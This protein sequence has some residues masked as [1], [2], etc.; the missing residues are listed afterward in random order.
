MEVKD[1]KAWALAATSGAGWMVF[2]I[3][4]SRVG[5]KKMQSI[6]H[7][8]NLCNKATISVLKDQNFVWVVLAVRICSAIIT[9]VCHNWAATAS[10]KKSKLIYVKFV[11]CVSS[12]FL[13]QK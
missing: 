5:L 12:A 6:W 4:L 11:K 1:K 10:E 7:F 9:I 3:G 8:A 13:E 2:N